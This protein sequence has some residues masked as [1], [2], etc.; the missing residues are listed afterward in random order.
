MRKTSTRIFSVFLLIAVF[1]LQGFSLPAGFPDLESGDTFLNHKKN[2]ALV[3]ISTEK[4]A[5]GVGAI[6]LKEGSATL[7]TYQA[8]D[9]NVTITEKAGGV[10]EIAIN[11]SSILQEEKTYFLEADADFVKAAD[12][13]QPSLANSW[14]VQVGDY[15]APV[16]AAA[17]FSPDNGETSVELSQNIKI[18][19]NEAVKVAADG[20][21]YIYEDNGTA[22]G[23]LFD[24]VKGSALALNDKELTINPT[25]DFTKGLTKYYVVIPNGAVVDAADVFGNDNK[26]KF[27]GWLNH[28]TWVFTTRDITAPAVKRIIQDNVTKD[29]FDVLVQLDKAGKVYVLAVAKD[30]AAPV[31]ADFV[32][33]KGMK[34]ADVPAAST[35]VRL[36]LSQFYDGTTAAAMQEES[37][38]DVYVYVENAETVTPNQ[39]AVAR[40]LTV[41]TADATNPVVVTPFYFPAN[42]ATDLVFNSTDSLKI[43]LSEPVRAGSGAVSIYTWDSSLN[44]TLLVSV[45]VSACKIVNH[46]GEKYLAIPVNQSLWASSAIYFVNFDEGIVTDGYGNPLAGVTTSG[47]WKFAVKDFQAPAYTTN[48]AD[49]AMGVSQSAPQ[50]TISFNETLYSD[51]AGTLMVTSNLASPLISLKKG[52]AAVAYTVDSFDGKVMKLSIDA[53]AVTSSAVF[54]LSIDT[55]KFFDLKGNNGTTVDKIEFAIRDFDVPVITIEP[56]TP[57]KSDNIVVNFNEPVFNSDGSAITDLDVSNIVIFRRGTSAS[58]AIV[59][60]SYSVSADAKSFIIDPPSDFSTPGEKYYV[61]IGSGA[62]KD[63]SGNAN[64]L[65]SQVVTISDFVDPTA[66]FSGIGTSPVDPASVA[67]VIT[68]SEPMMDLNGAAVSGDAT[69]LVTLKED[70]ENIPFTA[71]WTSASTISIV[72]ASGYAFGKTYTISVGKSLQDGAGNLF[73]GVSTTFTTWINNAPA[74]VAVS[75][76]DLATEQP[77]DIVLQVTFDQPVVAGSGSVSLS[78]TLATVGA[79]TI[80]GTVLKIAHSSFAA[81]ETIT[82]SIPAGF[83]KGLGGLGAP[84]VSWTFK[85]HETV[86][87][88]VTNY[89][90][91]VAS[92]SAGI[93]DKLVLTF[94][95]NIALKA[96]QVHIKDFNSDVTVQTLTEANALVMDGNKLEITLISDLVYGKKYYVVMPEGFVE[97]LHG[98]QFA[99]F[100]YDAWNFTT[101]TNPGAFVVTSSSPAENT[102]KIAAG[103][104]AITVDFNRDINP[105]SLSSTAKIILNDGTADV[106]AEVANS[107]R[108]SINGKVLTINTPGNI[109]ADKTYTL[110]LEAGVVKDNFN[111]GNTAKTIVFYTKDNYA[112]MVVSHTPAS[113]AV[114]VAKNETIVINWD[115]TPY[116]VADGSA[117]GAADIKANAL[118]TV[119]ALTNYTAS[120]NGL[121]WT[122]TLD[123]PLAENALCTVV[124]DLSKVK[125][126]NNIA[127]T[128]T[129]SW[130]FTT[131]DETAIAPT[132]FVVTE[133]TKGTEVR[134][135]IDFDE[136]GDVYYA[137]LPASANAPAA[138]E[139]E[140]LN[141]RIPFTASGTSAAVPVAGLTSGVAYNAYFVAV[142]ASANQ[143]P[144][145]A[146][147]GFTTADVVAPVVLAML[148]ANGA[149]DVAVDATLSLMFDEAVAIGTGFVVIRE[150]ATD[151]IAA[152]V[153]VNGTNTVLSDADKTATVTV[154][155]GNFLSSQT[156]YYVEVSAGAFADAAG[157]KVAAIS[158]NAA[159]VFTTKDVILPTLVKTTPDYTASPIEEMAVGTTLLM[160][161]NEAMKIGAGDVAIKYLDTD[162]IFEVVSASALSL[163][164]D[165]KSISINLTNVPAEQVSFYVDLAGLDL[166]DVSGNAW[167]KT[168]L[169]AKQWDF[170]ILDQTA[171]ALASSVPENNKMDVD[172]AANVT[173]TFT[174]N[175]F[176]SPDAA[177]FD[178]T[179][180]KSVLALKD[181]YGMAVDFS[182]TIAG[183]VVTIIPSANLKS[184]TT[185][186]VSVGPVVDNRKNVSSEIVVTFTTKDTTKPFAAVWN[187]VFD[188]KVNPKSGVVTVTFNEPVYDEVTLVPGDNPIVAEVL[189]ANIQNLFTYNFGTVT[190]DL[191][192]DIKTFTA[193]T[194]VAFSGTVTDRKTVVLTPSAPLASEAWYQ[195]ALNPDVVKD[196]SGNANVAGETVFQIE[197]HVKPVAT[198]YSPQGAT[199][200][201]GEMKIVFNEPVMLGTGTFYIRNYIDGTLVEAVAVNAVNVTVTGSSVVIAHADFAKNMDFYVNADPGA[202]TDLAGNA[203]DGIA[204]PQITKWKF[205]TADAVGPELFESDAL[206]PAPGATN[207][208]LNAELQIIFS[209]VVSKNAGNIVIYNEDWT[210]F[211]VIPVSA[212]VLKPFTNPVYQANRIASIVHDQFA[213][214]SKYFV[215][216]EAGTFKDGAGNLFAGLL[217]NTW[218]FTTEDNNAPV[219]VSTSPADNSA[220]VSALT[221]LTITFDR[222]VLVGAAGS[223]YLYQEVGNVG[224]LVEKFEP[225][226]ATKVT[227]AGPVVT[228]NR[229]VKLE[230]NANYY[231]IIDAGAF[232]STTSEKKSFA[233]IITTQGWNFSTSVTDMDKPFLVNWTPN[234]TTTA[235]NHPT[236]VMT[237][238]EDVVAG[239]GNLK[240]IKKDGTVPA[241][242]IPITAAMVS[243]NTV[244]VTY[245]YDPAVGGLDKSTDYY[246]L[247]DAGALKDLAG[248]VFDGVTEVTDWTFKTGDDFATGIDAKDK[249]LEFKVYPN[250]FAEY[251]QISNASELSKLVITNIAGQSVKEVINPAG[252]I[253]LNELRSGIYFISMY[254]DNVIAQTV[255]VIKK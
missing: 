115:E 225:T 161:F 40:K 243:G 153:A 89:V 92:V 43:Y 119:N 108:F 143:S 8:T 180:I 233:G 53:A 60:A 86:T 226:D 75:P 237:F 245:V 217:D 181:A 194:P 202:I 134:F 54:E 229:S 198:A 142:D 176:K 67:A 150:K 166:S 10:C 210:P 249:S 211:Q 111:T 102:D 110:T 208:A 125:D 70:G 146:P 141:L 94:D 6:R 41:T 133:N 84:A 109:V 72:P 172:L 170:S 17:P 215:R 228:I 7:G 209:K 196:I 19:F 183:N 105:G 154:G 224:L 62:V 117:I 159:W 189:D 106:F 235:D 255:K 90:P 203:W 28:T 177:A 82:V 14:V 168:P 247:V 218:S 83:V 87:P 234:Q 96:G 56:L 238:S 58:G 139:I 65:T 103:L 222:D 227:V 3:L 100:S 76:E 169:A 132:A 186:T 98:N 36:S 80:D 116:H 250:P 31:L 114:N 240:I 4:V 182:A 230:Y 51:A 223:I 63:A 160:E 195:V 145:Y 155:T 184:E 20:E 173:L 35:D 9:P 241:L 59:V 122:L 121:Q 130:S 12:D 149:V 25:R 26:N 79:V 91:S 157:N 55:R 248:N 37:P 162:A 214:M 163:S 22:F 11:F 232:T 23:D 21:V 152:T 112:P 95:E 118:V 204:A 244:T 85:T 48:P 101:V 140:A 251:I 69:S 148:P 97:D 78:G 113:N 212:V 167:D 131:I 71:N 239:A 68:F 81:D 66:A 120:V 44:H 46:T 207:V 206:S 193:G 5:A 47:E 138:D 129:Y 213:P 27:A 231:V 135:T 151:I 126:V 61:R 246:V 188:S 174:E 64:V 127:G 30:A 191:N 171:P 38:Y 220:G 190:R 185:Y 123:A 107:G 15:T 16:M 236:F 52:S 1:V 201:N 49:G 93:S 104:T 254:K 164:A 45:P 57:G 200:V 34:S 18:T 253:Q 221:D 29:A 2:N 175:I 158:G 24:I 156:E 187:P 13:G 147:S 197:D 74:V 73:Q 50:I 219:I 39:S 77:D 124:V 199:A 88:S 33:G 216:V 165:Q 179:T 136:A 99:G 128:G 32:S 192:G 178:N 252:K 205:S 42:G 137:V 144:V 242:T